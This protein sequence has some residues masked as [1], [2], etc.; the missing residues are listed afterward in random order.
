[1]QLEQVQ[2]VRPKATKTAFDSLAQVG[3][4]EI[5]SKRST[6]GRGQPVSP[7][8][9]PLNDGAQ[10]RFQAGRKLAAGGQTESGLARDDDTAATA[11]EGA[12]KQSLALSLG[13]HVGG[14]EEV[15]ARIARRREH[16]EKTT[17]ISLKDSADSGTPETKHRD[18]KVRPPKRAHLHEGSIHQMARV[19]E[20]GSA[21]SPASDVVYDSLVTA[22]RRVGRAMMASVPQGDS[23]VNRIRGARGS[24]TLG[25]VALALAGISL[26][27]AAGLLYAALAYFRAAEAIRLDP[28]GLSVYAAERGKAPAGLPLLVFFGD[29]RAAMW[30]Q[31]TPP[32]GY[33]ILNRGIGFQTTAQMLLRLDA[34]VT[35]LRPAVIVIEGG[36]NDLKTIADFPE[37]R[38]EIVAECK[39]NLQQIVERC[40]QSGATVVLVTVFR[41]GDLALWRRP[42][43]SSQVAAAVLEVNAFLPRLAGDRVVL[44]D[45]NSVLADG[46]GHI[47]PAYQLDY[48]HLS[49]AGYAALNERLSPLLATLPR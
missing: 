40:R 7:N 42:F 46:R 47:Q 32:A 5:L 6:G 1:V 27:A 37:R 34:D 39:A 26:C 21:A 24:R 31:P 10:N 17:G 14:I 33:R 19:R 18:G 23:R 16:I 12:A 4:R 25:I 11:L 22:D 29:S 36:V 20:V 8:S 41:I 38:T 2:I 30:L 13:I 9:E 43:W 15:D 49:S 28:A 35:S 3:G 45:A 44:F 48:L